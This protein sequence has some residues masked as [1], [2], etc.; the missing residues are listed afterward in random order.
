MTDA[1]ERRKSI[2]A[3]ADKYLAPYEVH[4]KGDGTEEIVPD[5]CPFC[6]GGTHGDRKSFAL[7][8][9]YGVYVCK[10][11]SCGQRGKLSTLAEYLGDPTRFSDDSGEVF[12]GRKAK[13]QYDRPQTACKAPTDEI[14]EYFFMRG[15]SPETVDAFKIASDSSGN[16]VFRFFLDGEDV[17]EKFRRPEK[18]DKSS[19]KPKEWRVPNTMAVL[20]NMDACVFSKPLIVTEGEIDSMALYEA[21]IK[22]VVS[23]PSGCEDMSWIENCWEWLEKFNSIVLF[24]DDDEPGQKMVREVARRLDESR[25]MIVENYP[26]RPNSKQTCKDANEILLRYGDLK[27]IQMVEDAKAV[28][29]RGL[30]NLADVTPYDPTMVPRIKTGIPSIDAVTGGLLEGGITAL[31]GKAG[32]GKSCLSTL[33]MLNAIE[34][35]Y[36]VCAYSGE[37]RSDRFQ[38]WCNFVAAGSEWIGLKYDKIKDKQVP[39]VPPKVA[40]RIMKWYNNKFLLFDNNETFVKNQADAIIQVF[41]TAIRRHG[42]KLVVVDNLLTSVSDRD[43]E[44]KAQAVFANQLKQLANRFG[45]AV[46]MVCHAR[47]TKAGEK[48]RADDLSGSSAVNNL[49]DLTIAVEPGRLNIIKNRDTGVLRS[50]DFCY[51]PDSKRIYEADKG[52]HSYFSW[53]REGLLPPEKRADSLPEY[54]VVYPTT[55]PF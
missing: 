20:F 47:K 53:D 17:F 23:V 33:I 51:C 3:F 27:L 10:R 4:K 37:F 28:P 41:T 18:Y 25:C 42:A 34:Q 48:L 8:I 26:T 15:I 2:L 30:L 38:S 44:W 39:I 11:G 14:Y 9:D 6:H 24:G 31:V 45:V 40:E 50:V 49:A 16:I 46:V 5:L 55:E 43:D 29:I 52:D 7:S 54:D 12:H 32:S 21:G 19:G 13:I 36:T 22:N 1:E 35:G